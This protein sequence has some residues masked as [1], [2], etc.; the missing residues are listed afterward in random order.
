[1]QPTIDREDQP[2]EKN[3]RITNAPEVNPPARFNCFAA[4][5]GTECERAAV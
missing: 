3:G 4:P 1:M 5:G 2:D